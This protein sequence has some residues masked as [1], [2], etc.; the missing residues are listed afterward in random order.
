MQRSATRSVEGVLKAAGGILL[1]GFLVWFG[2]A[3]GIWQMG[4]EKL[5][6]L[7]G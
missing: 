5:R 6:G 2:V 3:T 1:I 4:F 7:F